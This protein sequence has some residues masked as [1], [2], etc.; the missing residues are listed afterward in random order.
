MEITS[1]AA[2]PFEKCYLDIVGPL[3]LSTAG[4][5][6]ILTFQDDLSK[7]VVAT[8]INQQDATTV[9]KSFVS[10]I[11]LKYGAPTVVQTDQGANFVSEL[12][13]TTC[14][15]LKIKKIQSTAF[16]PESQGGIERS[17]RVLAEYLRHYVKEDQTDWDEWIPFANQ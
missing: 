8:P 4:N 9:A 6:Y 17:H 11:V 16:H 15:L 10:Q 3:P 13:K 5:K 2:H 7:Y 14:K 12:F 1:T